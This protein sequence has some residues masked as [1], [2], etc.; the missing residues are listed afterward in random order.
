MPHGTS[1]CGGG[2]FIFGALVGSPANVMV[3]MA[4]TKV[5]GSANEIRVF[6]DGFSLF[7]CEIDIEI[8]VA[9]YHCVLAKASD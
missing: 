6:I 2:V 3:D 8:L 4:S 9:V 7:V 1:Q 5:I